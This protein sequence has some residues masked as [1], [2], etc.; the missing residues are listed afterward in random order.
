M[1]FSCD[2]TDNSDCD[3][4]K[5]SYINRN[6]LKEKQN[7]STPDKS[8]SIMYKLKP[9]EALHITQEFLKRKNA[10]NCDEDSVSEDNFDCGDNFDC[11]DDCNCG[12]D[13]DCDCEDCNYFEPMIQNDTVVTSVINQFINR[14][15]VGYKK[16]GKTLDREDLSLLEWVQHAQE[17]HMDSILYLEK[18]K[19]TRTKEIIEDNN[20]FKCIQTIFNL[21]FTICL[22]SIITNFCQTYYLFYKEI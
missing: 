16:Y 12:D 8:S 20:K 4:I 5:C 22:V 18:I 6:R 2:L 10:Y 13:C 9:G 1:Y 7:V 17:E 19:K 21:L 3:C 15:N 11:R 14:A